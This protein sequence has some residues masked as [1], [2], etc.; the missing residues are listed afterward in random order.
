MRRCSA[1]FICSLLALAP[2]GCHGPDE[3][4]S[5]GTAV[6]QAGFLETRPETGE[7]APGESLLE[8]LEGAE[9]IVV[10]TVAHV[11]A[12]YGRTESGD[13]LI[14]S[15]VILRVH[16]TLRGEAAS[17]LAFELEGGTL[18]ALTLEVSDLPSLV[19]G[20]RGLFALRPRRTGTGL[21]PHRRGL[22]ILRLDERDRVPALGSLEE[23]RRAL[24]V[25]R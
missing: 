2:F 10:A 13:E 20:D 24:R 4:A 14:M 23:V 17:I 22:G 5:T 8:R 3:P 11:S 9:R 25:S 6:V 21:V 18:G 7:P 12:G 16:E 1:R 19:S 15:T